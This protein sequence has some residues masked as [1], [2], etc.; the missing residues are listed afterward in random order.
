[1]LLNLYGTHVVYGNTVRD[2][3]A[4]RR[5]L[6]TQVPVSP[7]NAAQLTG[8]TPFEEVRE[9]LQRLL[10]PEA[11]FLERLH[12]VTASSMISHGVDVDRL[13]VMTVLGVPLTTAEFIQATARVGRAHP[14]LVYV[15]HKIGRERDSAVFSQ[16]R[17]FIEQGD[18]FVEPIPITRASRRVLELTTSAAIESRRLFV[19]EPRSAG[20][21]LTTV[22]LLRKFTTQTGLTAEEE[23]RAC[24]A[25]LGVAEQHHLAFSDV[26]RQLETYFMR[27]ENPGDGAKWPNQLL[28]RA[29]MRSLRDVE[30]QIP[31][32]D[33]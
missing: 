5:S 23:A 31:V 12:V 15:I 27:L 4:A 33:D 10:R 28:A 7:L 11:N 20:G 14:G 24:A 17:P 26:S 3:E 22:D 8:Q 13:N 6:G 19:H 2:V 25:A 30:A 21:R 1:M 16:F 9:T 32:S 18:R 29:P